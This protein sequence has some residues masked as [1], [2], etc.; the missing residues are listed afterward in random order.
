MDKYARQHG[1]SYKLAKAA[2]AA[3]ISKTAAEKHAKGTHHLEGK[4]L[5]A[6]V[7]ALGGQ[8]MADYVCKEFRSPGQ[9]A[10]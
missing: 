5:S 2:E 9:P 10:P 1:L 7:Q 6:F 3:E 4:K 8:E